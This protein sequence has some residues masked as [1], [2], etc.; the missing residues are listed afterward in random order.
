MWTNDGKTP[1]PLAHPPVF[2]YEGNDSPH[3]V[4]EASLLGP[5]RAVISAIARFLRPRPPRAKEEMV[6][7]ILGSSPALPVPPATPAND[8]HRLAA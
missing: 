6:R 2:S 4:P 8:S 3:P 5:L 7:R 1:R